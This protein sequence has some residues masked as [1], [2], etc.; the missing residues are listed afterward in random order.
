MK[1]YHTVLLFSLSFDV[2]FTGDGNSIIIILFKNINF[3]INDDQTQ[4]NKVI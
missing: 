3:W 1:Y 4:K 2:T